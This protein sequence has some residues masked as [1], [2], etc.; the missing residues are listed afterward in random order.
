MGLASA[1]SCANGADQCDAEEEVEDVAAIAMHISKHAKMNTSGGPGTHCTVGQFCDF[2]GCQVPCPA[3][4]VCPTHIGC[5]PG[6][7]CACGQ[8]GETVPYPSSGSCEGAKASLVASSGN[9]CAAG[10]FCNHAGC[11]VPC[12]ANNKCPDTIGCAPGSRCACGQ[13]GETKP[14]PASGVCPR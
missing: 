1:E 3:S 12:P 9:A 8:H 7:F 6:S 11:Q 5:S 4:E 14:C 13:H 10:Q 2:F